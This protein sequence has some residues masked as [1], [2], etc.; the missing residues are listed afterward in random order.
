M[1]LTSS[2]NNGEKFHQKKPVL[3]L[4][5]EGATIHWVASGYKF[6]IMNMWH[7]LGPSSML[8]MLV[9][10]TSMAKDLP[11]TLLAKLSFNC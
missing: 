10:V 11:K 3:F 6:N 8:K 7:E 9:W 1:K 2:F 4:W 5:L